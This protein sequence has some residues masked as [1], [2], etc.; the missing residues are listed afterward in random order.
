MGT[1]VV[2][3]PMFSTVRENYEWRPNILRVS[4]CLVLGV[5]RVEVG[6]FG[7]KDTQRTILPQQDVI[8]SA[9]ASARLETDPL[10]IEQVPIAF[11]ESLVDQYARECLGLVRQARLSPHSLT[12]FLNAGRESPEAEILAHHG[13]QRYAQRSAQARDGGRA[14]VW[15]GGHEETA[16]LWCPDQNR[17][18]PIGPLRW[19]GSGVRIQ[20][21]ALT[22]WAN[23]WHA[24]GVGKAVAS[25]A[26]G[27][28]ASEMTGARGSGRR[29]TRRVR[30]CD[31]PIR[32]RG[33]QDGPQRKRAGLARLV[34]SPD[35]LG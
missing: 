10:R 22:G 19:V 15:A 13:A 25:G 7:L 6:P 5:I 33:A 32:N 17:D 29:E 12:A 23:V 24:Y 34:P 8:C 26:A 11:L 9:I 21:P 2:P 14:R 4:T 20:F 16:C 18:A 3:K 30:A 28:R 1:S 35:G 31:A 27:Q